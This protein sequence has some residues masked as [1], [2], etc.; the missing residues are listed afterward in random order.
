METTGIVIGQQ[1]LQVLGLVDDLNIIENSN[2]HIKRVAQVLEQAANKIGLKINT[3]K[4][5]IMELLDD[6]NNTSTGFLFL[7]FQKSQLIPVPKNSN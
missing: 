3:Y 1:H 7:R 2:E 5:K 6:R 4:T